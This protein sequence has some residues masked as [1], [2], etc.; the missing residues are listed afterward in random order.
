MSGGLPADRRQ[1]GRSTHGCVAA[2]PPVNAE[3]CRFGSIALS[4]LTSALAQLSDVFLT[5]IKMA[6]A[7]SW[8]VPGVRTY[9][10]PDPSGILNVVFLQRMTDIEQ[11]QVRDAINAVDEEAVRRLNIGHPRQPRPLQVKKWIRDYFPPSASILEIATAAHA[12]D[13]DFDPVFNSIVFVDSGWDMGNVIVA[14][15]ERQEADAEERLTAVRVPMGI[16]NV[17]LNA[18]DRIEGLNLSH[19]LGRDAFDQGQ[20]DFYKDLP[21]EHAGSPSQLPWPSHLPDDIKLDSDHPTIISL[22]HLDDVT[23]TQ[24]KQDIRE[25]SAD[26]VKD[27]QIYN[28]EGPEPTDRLLLRD[29]YNH[30]LQ[31]ADESSEK[32]YAFFFDYM[33]HGANGEPQILAVS[34]IAR[35]A[36]VGVEVLPVFT[37]ALQVAWYQAAEL[38][39]IDEDTELV[40]IWKKEHVDHLNTANCG[41]PKPRLK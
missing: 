34:R 35:D 33:L 14:H 24:L 28:W 41:E 31:N 39:E 3:L 17:L 20:V 40:D 15:W 29:L 12:D 37:S 26:G 2:L 22:R 11:Q 18:C 32:V 23:I 27:V 4:S 5:N 8:H 36:G 19:A 13:S 16:A 6:H 30:V 7:R 25:S 10:V 38:E 21:K 1:N 9:N